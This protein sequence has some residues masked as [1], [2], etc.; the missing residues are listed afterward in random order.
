MLVGVKLTIEIEAHRHKVHRHEGQIAAC[1]GAGL[2]TVARASAQAR[3]R[4]A[5]SQGDREP[6]LR[7]PSVRDG[8]LRRASRS[9]PGFGARSELSTRRRIGRTA[10]TWRAV[11]AR[12]GSGPVSLRCRTIA[13]RMRSN[14]A[15]SPR[16][17][18]GAER[19]K[20]MWAAA[21]SCG[22]CSVRLN[23]FVSMGKERV[24]PSLVPSLYHL[25][26]I[27]L[28]RLYHPST[29]SL[30]SLYHVSTIPLTSL[31]SLSPSPAGAPPKVSNAKP[32]AFKQIQR[33]PSTPLPCR[34]GT[35]ARASQC[36]M[37]SKPT[38]AATLSLPAPPLACRNST[39]TRQPLAGAFRNNGTFAGHFQAATRGCN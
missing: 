5:R 3:R 10:E 28:P 38:P 15:D 25:S 6:T 30:P 34:F 19:R 21:A 24:R 7:S 2:Q 4:A 9:Q 27:P 8:T 26:T 31:S 13:V 18:H 20:I 33:A 14:A 35:L 17:K 16:R 39:D 11:A 22:A 12:S 36:H 32:L 1:R 23:A 29:T 37:H